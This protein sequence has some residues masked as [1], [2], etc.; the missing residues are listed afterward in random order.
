MLYFI[1]HYVIQFASD[2]W[3]LCGFLQLHRFPPPKKTD[4]HWNIVESGVKHHNPKYFVCFSLQY[5]PDIK[6]D[7]SIDDAFRE[8][9]LNT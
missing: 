4:R 7:F 5:Y 1:Q 2:L 8:T 6:Y 3:W 9:T